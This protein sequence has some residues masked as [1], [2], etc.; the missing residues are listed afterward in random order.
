MTRAS[1]VLDVVRWQVDLDEPVVALAAAGPHLVA[2]GSE[3]LVVVLEPDSTERLRLQFGDVLLALAASPDGTRLA[4]GGPN[5]LAIW[6]LTDGRVLR[7]CDTRWCA[8]LDWAARSDQLVAADGRQV[9]VYDRDG[10]RRWTSQPLRSTVAGLSWVRGGRRVAAAAYQ[11]VTVFE[12]DTDRLVEHLPAP[13]AIAGLT[14]APSGRWVVGGSQDATLHGWKLPGGE[15]FM[16]SGFPSTVSQPAF[17]PTGRWMACDG[18][19]QI[20]CWDFS[21]N[22]PTGREALLAEGH[23]ARV[24]ALTWLPGGTSRVLFSGDAAGGLAL[25]R[26]TNTDRPGGRLRPQWTGDTGDPVSA[27]VGCG[28]LAVAGHRSGRVTGRCLP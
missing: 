9:R 11:G 19:A 27:A 18:G 14:V 2:G 25:W 5:S 26:I 6:D 16:M 8:A 23:D 1:A 7:R 28:D 13:G 15:D 4:A 22:G 12:P 21:G 17:E 20:A 3:G 10:S 24:S